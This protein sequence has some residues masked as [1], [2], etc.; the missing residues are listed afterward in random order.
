MALALRISSVSALP[1]VG[2]ACSIRSVSLRF[3]S[4]TGNADQETSSWFD[5][6][7][8]HLFQGTGIGVRD[9]G[10]HARHGQINSR[11]LKRHH[12]IQVKRQ[13][14]IGEFKR[15]SGFFRRFRPIGCDINDF[16]CSFAYGLNKDWIRLRMVDRLWNG[17]SRI[18]GGSSKHFIPIAR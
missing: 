11:P 2:T 13:T 12:H 5:K 18:C 10:N 14:G 3:L 16:F 9:M 17:N 7:F 8:Q 1:E 6:H 4:H 15:K